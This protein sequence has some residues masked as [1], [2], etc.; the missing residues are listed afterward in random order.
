MSLIDWNPKAPDITDLKFL[1]KENAKL[2]ILNKVDKN[3][4]ELLNK[5]TEEL[6]KIGQKFTS[7]SHK[8]LL[9]QIKDNNKI[10]FWGASLFLKNFLAKYKIKNS[11][12]LG[13]VDKNI[14]LQGTN[15]SAYEIFALSQQS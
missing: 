1:I 13:I 14:N 11:N 7:N 10:I 15:I 8:H 2:R 4:L 3:L 9:K 6:Y 5:K 12:I